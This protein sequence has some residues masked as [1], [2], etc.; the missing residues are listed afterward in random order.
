MPH[1]VG[2]SKLC[3]MDPNEKAQSLTFANCEK[4]LNVAIPSNEAYCI[5]VT[6]REGV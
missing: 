3:Y 1:I 6:S 5:F 2:E 4:S